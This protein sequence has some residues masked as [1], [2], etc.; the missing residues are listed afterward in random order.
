MLS[1]AHSVSFKIVGVNGGFTEVSGLLTLEEQALKLELESADAIV[2]ILR[3]D[4]KEIAIPFDRIRKVTLNSGF[5]KGTKL[6]IQTMSLADL[7]EVPGSKSGQVTL[8]IKRNDKP[9]AVAFNSAFQ[10][11]FSEYR[12]SKMDE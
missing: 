11:A 4:V 2:G 7:S 1:T 12:L 8:N 9:D 10:L 3:S 6:L 5:F